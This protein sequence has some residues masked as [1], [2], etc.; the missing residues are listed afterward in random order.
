MESESILFNAR[1][2]A[3]RLGISVK[4]LMR[5]VDR[6]QFPAPL[7]LGRCCRWPGHVINEWIRAASTSRNTEGTPYE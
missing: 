4:H 2:V 6:D 1:A 3:R 7:R 5:L